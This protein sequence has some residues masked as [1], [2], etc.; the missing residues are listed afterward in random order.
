[1]ENHASPEAV[2]GLLRGDL[3]QGEARDLVTHLI[4]GCDACRSLFRDPFS[5][6]DYDGAFSVLA[7]AEDLRRAMAI[8]NFRG[9]ADWCH[10][11]PLSQGQR[12]MLV[13]NKPRFQHLGLYNRLLA[14]LRETPWEDPQRGVEL[15]H[16]AVAV[17]H[18][19][20]EEE[21]GKARVADFKGRA[22]A[23]LGNAYRIHARYSSARREIE[24]AWTHLVEGTGDPLEE[25]EL[26]GQCA[27]L[28]LHLGHFDQA[29]ALAGRALRKARM[30]GDEIAQAK[31]LIQQ[32]DALGHVEPTRAIPLLERA[33]GLL[34]PN[35]DWCCLCARHNL[36]W[37]LNDA[38]RSTEAVQVLDASRPLYGQFPHTLPSLALHWLEGRIAHKIGDL[39]TGEQILRTVW[40]DFREAGSGHHF[41]IVA[42]DLAELLIERGKIGEAVELLTETYLGMCSWRMDNAA[43]AA[44][45]SV[46][47]TVARGAATLAV[48]AQARLTFRRGFASEYGDADGD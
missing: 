35:D 17:A 12:L 3:P 20:S 48:L 5:S 30:A 44:M 7:G 32:A 29:Y 41:P 27:S 9:I 24:E 6:E 45:V 39:G 36:A 14:L 10:L 13:C 43:L 34:G 33:L 31:A 16:L 11:E 26:L 42:V 21:Y 22:H 1:M 4:A 25:F 2:R 38:G 28:Q 18:R 8:M 23:A 40:S 37:F 15:A 47:D 19:L 46:R